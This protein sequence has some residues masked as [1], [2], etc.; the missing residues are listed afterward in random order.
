MT[1]YWISFIHSLTPNNS[2]GQK[3]F[4]SLSS[5]HVLQ[6]LISPRPPVSGAP[7]WIIYQQAA[8]NLLFRRHGSSV[9]VDDWRKEGI[10]FINSLGQQMGH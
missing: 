2:G 9:E 8:T 5:S 3:P 7:F 4:L 6:A 1:S 10:A